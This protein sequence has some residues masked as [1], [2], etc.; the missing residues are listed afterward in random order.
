M[1]RKPVGLGA[2]RTTGGMVVR[3]VRVVQIGAHVSSSGGIHT[4]ID[5]AEAIGAEAVQVFT[6]SPRMWK[7]TNHP[8][9]NVERFKERAVEAGLNGVVC[10]ALYLINLAAPDD[11]VYERSVTALRSSVDVA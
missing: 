6:Q 3:I 1:C 11:G 5:R 9:E 4:A 10:H 8:D 2:K 7:P